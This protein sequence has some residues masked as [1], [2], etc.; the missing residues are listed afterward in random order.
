[1]GEDNGRRV[2]EKPRE[3][4]IA[5]RELR[6]V[7]GLGDAEI[8][9][10]HVDANCLHAGTF[11]QRAAHDLEV[12]PTPRPATDL[13][14]RAGI[15]VDVDDLYRG[16]QLAAVA[17]SPVDRAL[18]EKLERPEVREHAP[19][20]RKR[21]QNEEFSREGEPL[22]RHGATLT[23]RSCDKSVNRR[24]PHSVDTPSPGVRSGFRGP[25]TGVVSSGGGSGGAGGL[26]P[27]F[28]GGRPFAPSPSPF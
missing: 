13:V 24:N 22:R 16:L 21:E 6:V 3:G 1:S 9:Q 17:K 23:T 15:D 7:R 14:Q 19:Q 4:E 10:H 25:I 28:S 8:G 26:S 20:E 5:L 11:D 2:V 18:L 12:G 27:S